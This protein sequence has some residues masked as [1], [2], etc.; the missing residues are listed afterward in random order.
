MEKIEA[1][2]IFHAAEVE[3]KDH[4]VVRYYHFEQHQSVDLQAG[5]L[6]LFLFCVKQGHM[7]LHASFIP[8]P[9]E[10][11]S[12]RSYFPGISKRYMAR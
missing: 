12:G 7:S 2:K 1:K 6:E 10:L 3:I 11:S 5:P 9:I 8:H 4:G